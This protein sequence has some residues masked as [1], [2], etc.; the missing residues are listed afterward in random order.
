M[1]LVKIMEVG[2]GRRE[3]VPWLGS[4]H[5]SVLEMSTT[6]TVTELRVMAVSPPPAVVVVNPATQLNEHCE[7]AS[8]GTPSDDKKVELHIPEVLLL[9][10][11]D[12]ALAAASTSFLARSALVHCNASRHSNGSMEAVEEVVE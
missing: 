10:S 4:V 9:G 8:L 7:V 11:G 12:A 2:K 6:R 3:L 1:D 5:T